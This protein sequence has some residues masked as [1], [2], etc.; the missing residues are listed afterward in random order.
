MKLNRSLVLLAGFAVLIL[1]L[2]LT[3]GCGKKQT[4]PAVQ[5]E[6]G[7]TSTPT[8]PTPK[9]VTPEQPKPA[10]QSA[11]A[12]G[13]WQGKSMT[14]LGI[15][16][17][18]F[19]FDKSD[20]D[21]RAMRSLSNNARVL[22]QYKDLVLMIEGHCDERGTTEYNI[23]LGERRANAARDYLASLGVGATQ[24]R[25]TSYGEERPFAQGHDE[26]AWAQNRRAHFVHP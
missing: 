1:A 26:E 17:V 12:A 23:A 11:S 3:A 22:K 10:D 18:Y 14:E 20:L 8:T 7:S 13:A 6:P 15:E 21:D 19:A 4:A 2:S 24:V 25:T 16:D 9:P 5:T